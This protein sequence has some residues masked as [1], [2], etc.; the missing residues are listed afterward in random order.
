MSRK[1]LIINGSPR[2]EGNTVSMI[3]ELKKHLTG[4]VIEISAFYSKIAPCVDCRGCWETAK[5]VVEDDMKILY[6]DDFDNVLLAS[7][8]YF[9]DLPGQVLNLMSRFQPQHVAQYFL[10]NPIVRKEKRA[11]LIFTAGGR[12]NEDKAIPHS[13]VLFRLLNAHGWEEHIAKSVDTDEIPAQNDRTA[14]EDVRKIAAWFEQ[15]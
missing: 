12:H 5:C 11:G 15:E 6:D 3:E 9:F 4:E 14:M 13:A 10:K 1:T 7:P 8:V 2:K